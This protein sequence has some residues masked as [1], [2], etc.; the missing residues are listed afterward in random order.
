[1]P[2][3]AERRSNNARQAKPPKEIFF[4]S[5]PIVLR[6]STTA[7][8]DMGL[9]FFSTASLLWLLKWFKNSFTSKAL[10]I[11][12]VF[13]GLALGT[14][15][16]GLVTLL[17]LTCII[18]LFYRKYA[19]GDNIRS[20]P[21]L[22]YAAIFALVAFVLFLPWLI[23]NYVWT[24]NPI[25]PLFDQYFSS[26][27]HIEKGT[28]GLLA[29]R[30][31]AYDERWWHLALLPVRIFFQG[32]D[33][34]PQYFDGR[35]NPFLLLLP[36]FAFIM[37]RE[38]SGDLRLD[39]R[40]LLLFVLLFFAFTFLPGRLRIRYISPIIP[41]LI[42][43]SSLG[44]KAL[45]DGIGKVGW[46]RRRRLGSLLA[47]IL[48]A[49]VLVP[50]GIYAIERFQRLKPWGYIS[51]NHSRDDYIE[52]HRPEYAAFQ[53]INRYLP[54]QTKILF[55]FMGKRGYYCNRPYILDM[56]GNRSTFG[57][58]VSNAETPGE[59]YAALH[60]RG[61]THLLLNHKIF[62][63]WLTESFN[64]SDLLLLD[65]F[66]KDYTTSIFSKHGYR[67]FSLV[68]NRAGIQVGEDRQDPRS[69]SFNNHGDK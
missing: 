32:Q 37:A 53:Y 1:M 65:R 24:G 30:A 67:L 29:F 40:V 56:R 69:L 21:A 46:V 17:S 7:Y 5:L 63:R 10:L 20:L 39:K 61:I 23:R 9:V 58:I 43:L 15:Y 48:V 16:N 47:F 18:P 44:L 12:G 11:S 66:F 13:C 28:V 8:V 31:Y 68:D 35:L 59:I 60:I 57:Q 41:P 14:K 55:M 36:V 49:A 45:A 33:G 54:S 51:G 22:R 4:L 52:R 34:S 6:L 19:S 42:I 64:D 50:N 26:E 38:D 25:Y 2:K 62:F 3:R 27:R